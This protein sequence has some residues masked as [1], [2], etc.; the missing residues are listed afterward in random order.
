MS[1]G[2]LSGNTSFQKF[3]KFCAIS[4]YK[5]KARYLQE[6]DVLFKDSFSVKFILNEDGREEWELKIEATSV[7]DD[8]ENGEATLEV[9]IEKSTHETRK[10]PVEIIY[11]ILESHEDNQVQKEILFEEINNM[12][13]SR[14]TIE[15]DLNSLKREGHI[16]EKPDGSLRAVDEA[17]DVSSDTLQFE[18]TS[19]RVRPEEILE[20]TGRVFTV[21]DPNENVEKFVKHIADDVRSKVHSMYESTSSFEPLTFDDIDG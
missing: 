10:E 4:R 13:V 18:R 8:M 16:I 1:R 20:D 9:E 15:D 19:R 7:P 21:K 5:V 3:F 14:E 11:N 6:G 2:S 12:E 17:P